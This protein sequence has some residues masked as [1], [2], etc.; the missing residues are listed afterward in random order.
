MVFWQSQSDKLFTKYFL[1]LL[2]VQSGKNQLLDGKNTM[3][4]GF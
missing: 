3:I 1:S 2:R 4:T